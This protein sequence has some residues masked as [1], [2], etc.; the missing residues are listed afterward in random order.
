MNN[1][2]KKKYSFYRTNIFRAFY[3]VSW[4]HVISKR[5]I[6]LKKHDN[7]QHLIFKNCLNRPRW[8]ITQ[9]LYAYK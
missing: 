4:Q 8:S 6:Y 7:L 3:R 9:Y 2:K 1:Y 5:N